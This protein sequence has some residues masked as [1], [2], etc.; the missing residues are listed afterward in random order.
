MNF[1]K[2]FKVIA[3]TLILLTI[4]SAIG[5]MIFNDTPTFLQSFLNYLLPIGG[6]LS[7]FIILFFTTDLGENILK[8]FDKTGDSNA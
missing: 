6:G 7:I 4:C 8:K 2:L 5:V 1:K 3:L